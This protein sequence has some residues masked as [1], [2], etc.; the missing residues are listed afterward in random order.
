MPCSTVSNTFCKS[1]KVLQSIFRSFRF[2]IIFTLRLVRARTVEFFL[3]KNRSVGD[4]K[5]VRIEDITGSI[6]IN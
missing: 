3:L 2:L 6:I 1:T 4:R 5:D